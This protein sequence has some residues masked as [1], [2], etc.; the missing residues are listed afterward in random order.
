[1]KVAVNGTG[2]VFNGMNREQMKKMSE[3]DKEIMVSV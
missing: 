2:I 3:A 1:M